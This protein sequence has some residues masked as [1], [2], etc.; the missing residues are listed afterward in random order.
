M[1]TL[2]LFLL[3]FSTLPLRATLYPMS[4]S[5][6]HAHR[7]AQ[8]L[9]AKPAATI[10]LRMVRSSFEFAL[11]PPPPL[12]CRTVPYSTLPYYSL[13]SR[14]VSHIHTTPTNA[15]T[16]SMHHHHSHVSSRLPSQSHLTPNLLPHHN[17]RVPVS[18][19]VR[20]RLRGKPSCSMPRPSKF[21]SQRPK[22][23]LRYP[24]DRLHAPSTAGSAA[25]SQDRSFSHTPTRAHTLPHVQP[26]LRPRK[27]QEQ[28]K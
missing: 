24:T 22:L 17:N 6:T 9:V 28:Q 2:T 23:P 3:P 18:T 26:L 15:S 16:S 21:P 1:A 14:S 12:H 5:A 8:G 11:L 20:I 7:T 25:R 19:F 4:L 27:I 13:P 10:F